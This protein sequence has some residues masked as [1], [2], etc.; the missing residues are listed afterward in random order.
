MPSEAERK[1]RLIGLMQRYN[2]LGRL[3]PEAADLDPADPAAITEARLVLR[4]MEKT[5]CEIDKI[6]GAGPT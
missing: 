4:E 5:K 2:Q 1:Q 3:L 6:L